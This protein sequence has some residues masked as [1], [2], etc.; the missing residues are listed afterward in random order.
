M[1]VIQY[2][3]PSEIIAMIE[4]FENRNLS[5]IGHYQNSE[6]ELDG[7]KKSHQRTVNNYDRQLQ[8]LKDHLVVIQTTLD[9]FLERAAE[10]ELCCKMFSTF[11][12]ASNQD[13][14]L[15][16]FDSKIKKGLSF[17]KLPVL[18]RCRA[19][20]GRSFGSYKHFSVYEYGRICRY[21]YASGL[22]DNVNSN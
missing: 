1:L 2:Q 15:T 19:E 11:E 8:L 13:D 7:I 18:Y 22:F 4:D 10:L 6:E 21:R 16:Q 14:I 12:E 17:L 5:L 20:I 3:N 9:R